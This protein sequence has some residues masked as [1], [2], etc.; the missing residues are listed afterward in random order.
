MDKII[1]YIKMH[2]PASFGAGEYINRVLDPI[3]D[4]VRAEV[5]LAIVLL[6]RSRV[7]IRT[8][9][10]SCKEQAFSEYEEFNRKWVQLR[11]NID[12]IKFCLPED[13]SIRAIEEMLIKSVTREVQ[14]KL[15]MPP[16]NYLHESEINES[17]IDWI[18]KKISDYLGKYS[19]VYTSFRVKLLLTIR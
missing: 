7:L 16:K 8:G 1:E 6:N 4:S 12:E 13:K 2:S 9:T 15:P 17:D 3:H 5:G 14:S 10:S 18:I 11:S 19:Q